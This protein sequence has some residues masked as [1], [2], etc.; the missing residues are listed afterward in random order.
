M[1][2][3]LLVC[4]NENC[5]KIFKR[6]ASEVKRS[7]KFKRKSYCF[8]S[9]ATK[10]NNKI[11]IRENKNR[12]NISKHCLNKIDEYSKFK[13][14]LKGIIQ[15]TKNKKRLENYDIDLPY[16]KKIWESQNGIC[17]ITGWNLILPKN[18]SKWNDKCLREKRASLDRIDS[19]KGYIKGN[20]RFVSVVFNYA[21]NNLT[22][23][24]VKDFCLAVVNNMKKIKD[25]DTISPIVR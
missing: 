21:K 14:F 9:C 16:L 19:T 5:K 13:W 18:A 12:Y 7:E 6:N 20:V 3:V 1:K 17:P 2:F 23:K 22:D 4:D 15:R 24:I 25:E 10:S 8:M 11:C